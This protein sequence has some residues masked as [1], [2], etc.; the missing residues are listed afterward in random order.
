MKIFTTLLI[1]PLLLLQ[2]AHAN[3]QT[4]LASWYGSENKISS[5]GK[6][7]NRK[8][9]AAA[10]RTLPIGTKVII[11]VKDTNK[12]I[13]AVIEDRGPYIKKRIIDVNKFAAKQLGFVN[14]GLV[15]VT[16]TPVQFPYK[17]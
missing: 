16:V 12:S 17:T 5:T 9:P 13:M 2:S 14:R 7:L 8:I 4:G 1:F 10:H 11:T 15:K 6:R 3:S